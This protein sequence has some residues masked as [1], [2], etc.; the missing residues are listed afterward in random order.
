MGKH[1]KDKKAME[2]AKK[3][4][5]DEK[6]IPEDVAM[7]RLYEQSQKQVQA[8]HQ[9]VKKLSKLSKIE[10]SGG[11]FHYQLRAGV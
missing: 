11:P 7:Q 8:A 6:K 2:S 9:L 1:R 3:D 5:E 4:P 10:V